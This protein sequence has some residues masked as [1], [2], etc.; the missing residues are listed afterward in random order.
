VSDSETDTREPVLSTFWQG[1]SRLEEILLILL[2][3]A[4]A[5]GLATYSWTD[6]WPIGLHRDWR[7]TYGAGAVLFFAFLFVRLSARKTDVRHSLEA[8][9]A[10]FTTLAV[11]ATGYWY[12][13]ERPGVPKI[14]LSTAVEAWPIGDRMAVIRVEMTI[15][16][17]GSTVVE[18]RE[19]RFDG[20]QSP[21]DDRIK[22]D[23]GRVLPFDP[24]YEGN[25][26]LLRANADRPDN[27]EF[28]VVRTSQWPPIGRSYH[29]SKGEIEAGETERYY[30]KAVVPCVD[31][32]VVAATA[33]VPKVGRLDENGKNLV[34]LAQA[35][36]EP[37]KH[38]RT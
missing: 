24:D 18:F 19:T 31:G 22:I 6:N 13:Y 34:W 4:G 20:T 36:S 35:L 21:R 12:F 26:K 37:V 30:Y 8:L 23:L 10:F 9:A 17:V 27:G 25:A 16:N 15:E 3:L 5:V 33:R 32:M 14:N 2:A 28:E 7:L 38:C 11:L 29:F 1:L